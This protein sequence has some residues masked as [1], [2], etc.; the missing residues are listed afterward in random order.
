M[1]EKSFKDYSLAQI[2][3]HI[4]DAL[5]A[6]ISPTEIV[7]AIQDEIRDLIDYHQTQAAKAQK[8]LNLLSGY[9]DRDLSPEVEELVEDL[10]IEQLMKDVKDVNEIDHPFPFKLDSF[11]LNPPNVYKWNNKKNGDDDNK[12][13]KKRK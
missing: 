9:G 4:G 13:N 6:D 10:N 3:D 7:R 5:S 11:G 12:R 2:R 1:T 8:T